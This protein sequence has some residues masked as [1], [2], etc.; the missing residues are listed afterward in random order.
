MV[1]DGGDTSDTKTSQLKNVLKVMWPLMY[2][3]YTWQ[4]EL[5]PRVEIL[6]GT[7]SNK[8]IKMILTLIICL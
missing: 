3:K 2:F 8:G 7:C 1:G 6:H 5:E 4:L